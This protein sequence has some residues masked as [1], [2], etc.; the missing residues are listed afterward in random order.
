MEL[1]E[2]EYLTHMQQVSWKHCSTDDLHLWVVSKWSEVEVVDAYAD[3]E[4]YVQWIPVNQKF[5]LHI[6]LSTEFHSFIYFCVCVMPVRSDILFTKRSWL[7]GEELKE[8]WM[9]WYTI[10]KPWKYTINKN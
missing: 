2:R 7:K 1:K 4:V 6:A 8:S 5:I 3:R 10:P 9:N